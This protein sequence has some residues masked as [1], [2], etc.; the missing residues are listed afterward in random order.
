MMMKANKSIA[1]AATLAAATWLGANAVGAVPIT[2]AQRLYLEDEVIAI[3]HWGL[4]T[5][6]GQEWGDGTTNP[7]STFP[8]AIGDTIDPAQWARVMKEGG[9]RKVILVA[10]HHDGFCLWPATEDTNNGYSTAAFPDGHTFKDYNLVAELNTA[11]QAEG[12]KFGV[13]L[14]P[15]DRH[16]ADW[17]HDDG[18]YTEYFHSQVKHMIDAYPVSEM[19]FDGAQGDWG[20]Y[21]GAR[22]NRS[23]PGGDAKAYYRFPEILAYLVDRHPNAVVFGGGSGNS[24]C[25]SGNELGNVPDGWTYDK[26]GW[27]GSPEADT[28][29]GGGG[30]KGQWFWHPGHNPKPL[31]QM[32]KN[33]F[34]SVGRGG[35]L[36][37]GV[38]PDQQGRIPDNDATRLKEF[39]D[40]IRAFNASDLFSDAVAEVSEIGD[41]R[42][43]VTLSVAA[44]RKFN[45]VDFGENL[46]DGQK[47]T[48]WTVEA[49]VDGD[50]TEL[51]NGTR[52]GFRRIV[53]IGG[54]TSSETV[55]ADAVRI[56]A[57][58]ATL[59]A[60]ERI[61][62]RMANIVHDDGSVEIGGTDTEEWMEKDEEGYNVVKFSE[63]TT[64][65]FNMPSS[66]TTYEV[67]IK[68]TNVV[69]KSELSASS[70]P[71]VITLRGADGN[72]LN[73]SVDAAGGSYSLFLTGANLTA[74][75]AGTMVGTIGNNGD[76]GSTGSW[77]TTDGTMTLVL[78]NDGTT[79]SLY[80]DGVLVLKTD[81]NF[82]N[83]GKVNSITVG[84]ALESLGG[85]VK[86][87]RYREAQ[88]AP[89]GELLENAYLWLD[90]S[91]SETIETDAGGAVTSWASRS[92]ER[93]AARYSG[94]A[95]PTVSAS[96]LNGMDVVDFG[97]AGSGMDLGFERSTAIRTVFMVAAVECNAKVF[98][99]G[100]NL[101][102]HFHRGDNG[103]YF[104]ANHGS[105]FTGGTYLNGTLVTAPATT[106]PPED[107]RV[108]S[109][110]AN[111]NAT[112]S[113]I[114]QDRAFAARSGGKKV[115][116][117][118]IFNHT[119]TDSERRQVEGYLM[120]KWFGDAYY[121]APA[122]GTVNWSDLVW[123]KGGVPGV[124][125]AGDTCMIVATGQTTV[126]VDADV[127]VG[128]ILGDGYTLSINEGCTLVA[129]DIGG[130]LA[131]TGMLM[132]T[133]APGDTLAE[134]LRSP[135][136]RGTLFCR[137]FELPGGVLL[138]TWGNGGSKIQLTGCSG[139]IGTGTVSPE[140]VLV[141]DGDTKA[142]TISA[143]SSGNKWFYGFSKVS[144][145]GTLTLAASDASQ[146]FRPVRIE[147]V[148]E[149]EGTIDTVQQGVIVGLGATDSLIVPN[150]GSGMGVYTGKITLLGDTA[151]T[152]RTRLA[153]DKIALDSNSAG[154]V[155]R[156][157]VNAGEP[158]TYTYR[159]A[160]P[161]TP[162]T[163]VDVQAA[164]ETEA[165]DK[166]AIILADNTAKEAQT[167]LLE[168]G[169][170]KP[171]AVETGAGTWT[172]SAVIDNERLPD[173]KRLEDVL[174]AFATVE[175][176]MCKV[177]NASADVETVAVE[178]PASSA[179]PGLYYSIVHADNLAFAN[180]VETPYVLASG[181]IPLAFMIS[182][183]D[184]R[185]RFFK[186]KANITGN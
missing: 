38:A 78:R 173:G 81:K 63:G 182:V 74:S 172:V 101:A 11:C 84:T 50:W 41:K 183:S 22:E 171:A 134:K 126:K 88:K 54:V 106:V 60:L 57:W 179:T 96:T 5:F 180:A 90:A 148:T 181:D 123:T 100:D 24:V 65:Q 68:L 37:W 121:I 32:V 161:L 70:Y 156:E 170:I 166:V 77:T 122:S 139:W 44:A 109:F 151:L 174:A 157:K 107:F 152:V 115:A 137:G 99:L 175:D 132:V 55:T 143:A 95:G 8:T 67:E 102:Y 164:S 49:N 129:G 62:V 185:T 176:G 48:R 150:D 111:A 120:E 25:W 145:T 30:E 130:E 167:V 177:L 33:Y 46:D 105:R 14:S 110:V 1:R 4:N 45:T 124:P 178:I 82:T 128:D 12:L 119:L 36:N 165:A 133:E 108:F 53:R 19:W 16:H 34:E 15:W 86:S 141:D 93:S 66:L 112:A 59:P 31:K 155:V 159:R 29:V 91:A 153:S 73:V 163:T 72:W 154:Y 71:K 26:G 103:T 69:D 92:G 127:T 3:V 131:G 116:E 47:V 135:K 13:Y 160:I 75:S 169:A 2:Q 9:I 125:G 18:K 17:G 147:D 42:V 85:G 142:F 52:L 186:A 113:R 158:V 7:A 27:F 168:N 162:E 146:T 21:G 118:L 144:G 20:Y 40:F 64:P 51:A 43:T 136:W 89:V 140:L 104:H 10:K 114:C 149:F 28:P 87:V 83:G 23:L 58:G 39:G 35:V 61:H 184:S 97:A 56:S 94:K 117:L 80:K 98:M 76:V 138:S 79:L 6:T